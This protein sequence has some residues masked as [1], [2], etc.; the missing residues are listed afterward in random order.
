VKEVIDF[1]KRS[2]GIDY[3]KQAMQRYFDQSMKMI[4]ELPESKYRTSLGQLVRFTI[5]RKS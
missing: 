5:E 3:A 2:G 4:E 1:V